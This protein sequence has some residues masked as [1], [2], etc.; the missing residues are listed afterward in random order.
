MVKRGELQTVGQA[1]ESTLVEKTVSSAG[2]DN[3]RVMLLGKPNDGK[4]TSAATASEFCPEE[5]PA[6]ELTFL[7]DMQWILLDNDG[8]KGLNRLNL[9]VDYIDLTQIQPEDIVRLCREAIRLTAQKMRDGK[10]KTCVFDS[11][12][13]FSQLLSAFVKNNT[14]ESGDG[15]WATW[16]A[17]LA[18]ATSVFTELKSLPGNLIVISHVRAVTINIDTKKNPEEVKKQRVKLKSQGL[19]EG[20]LRID[21]HGAVANY[22]RNNFSEIWPVWAEGEKESPDRIYTIHPYGKEGIEHKSKQRCFNSVEPANLQRMFKK[23]RGEL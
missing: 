21:V 12:S 22:Y 16:D 2:W 5:L 17:V 11:V 13:T 14:G 15:S 3:Y 8:L 7:D 23:I 1:I 10:K 18:K 4:T 19:K 6:K 20:D 9:D